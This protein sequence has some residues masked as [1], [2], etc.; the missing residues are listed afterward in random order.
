M[1]N[2]NDKNGSSKKNER[3]IEANRYRPLP[4]ANALADSIRAVTEELRNEP[5][6]DPADRTA[7]AVKLSTLQQ[8]CLTLAPLTED[9]PAPKPKKRADGGTGVNPMGIGNE[10][11]ATAKTLWF[12]EAERVI[13]GKPVEEE[14]LTFIEQASL[15]AASR[16]VEKVKKKSGGK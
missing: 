7:L 14:L 16:S 15:G 11:A 6:A 5:P 1:D 10:W 8:Q 12:I 4:A 2:H 13:P 3:F 9:A